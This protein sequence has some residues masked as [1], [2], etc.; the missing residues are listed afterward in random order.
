MNIKEYKIV[1]SLSGGGYRASVFHLGTLKKLNELDLLDKID[2]ISTI[3]GGSI[4]GAAW[5]LHDGDYN[6]FHKRMAENFKTKSVLR[7]ILTS[8]IFIRTMLFA[9]LFLGGGVFL[10]FTRWSEFSILLFVI[11]FTV[12]F[13]FQY[14]VFPISK[15]IVK[16]YDNFFF[17]GKTLADLKDRPVIAIGS[18]NLHSGRPFTFS[19]IKMS[20]SSYIFRQE[21]NPPIE[22]TP[23]N[24]PIAAAVAA[25]SCVPFAFSPITIDKVFFATQS[26]FDRVRPIL[27]DGGVYDNQGI[28]KL[29]QSKS[30]YECNLII[31]SDAGG[32]FIASKK[33]PN[34]I[35]LLS[36][37]VDLFM[38][39]IKAV[40]MIQNIYQNGENKSRPVAYFSLGWRIDN[41]VQGFVNNMC[42]GNILKDVID[43]HDF[44]KE[45]KEK[46]SE[47]KEEIKLHLEKKIN[48]AGIK[49]RD[50]TEKQWEIARTTG[51]NL[52][53]L[54]ESQ[55]K[56]LIVH[57]ENFTEL[58]IKLY[59]PMLLPAVV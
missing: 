42:N 48:F 27:I 39:R 12:I 56:Y 9:L 35:S 51:T 18:S 19:K 52:S 25:S 33:Y 29:T 54:S 26:D 31:T 36:R 49:S 34:V 16:A 2:V 13:C 30:T 57:A 58:Q 7:K 46:P 37:T 3:S 32:N 4:T 24:F 14:K 55:I 38:Y 40:Q 17:S 8:W 11:F 22:F 44:E 47:F 20:D 45:W 50:L 21:Y 59:C 28:Q 43:F 53:C 41:A 1:L 6:S 23:D 10:T 15:V 5:C